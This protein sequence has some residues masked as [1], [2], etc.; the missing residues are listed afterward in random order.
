MAWFYFIIHPITFE[1]DVIRNMN[2]AKKKDDPAEIR[3]TGTLY[4]IRAEMSK[5]DYDVLMAILINN[6]S[7]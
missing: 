7:G 2:G 6:F 1:L 4:E 3:A 5:N